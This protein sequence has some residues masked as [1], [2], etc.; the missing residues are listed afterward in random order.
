V[1]SANQ[2]FHFLTGRYD[3]SIFTTPNRLELTIAPD[4]EVELNGFAT[5][6][7]LEALLE[8]EHR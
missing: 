5:T 6:E 4:G 1:G 2:R 3:E 7:V 8:E